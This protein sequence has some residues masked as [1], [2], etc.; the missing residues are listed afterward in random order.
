MGEDNKAVLK[1]FLQT[2]DLA[3]WNNSDKALHEA[4]ASK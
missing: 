4:L 3:M 2:H 1:D